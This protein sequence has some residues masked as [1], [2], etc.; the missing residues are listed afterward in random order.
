[1]PGL[2]GDVEFGANKRITA[3]EEQANA[4]FS[5]DRRSDSRARYR[6]RPDARSPDNAGIGS[7]EPRT[8]PQEG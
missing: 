3:P 5:G 7:T 6:G 8:G 2:C 4:P 1:M